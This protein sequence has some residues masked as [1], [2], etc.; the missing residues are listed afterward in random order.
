MSEDH[1]QRGLTTEQ[2]RKRWPV[3]ISLV[4]HRESRGTE[5]G[6]ESSWLKRRWLL[7]AGC[8]KTEG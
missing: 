7:Y 2:L 1:A 3:S 6:P 5:I 8:A 4:P